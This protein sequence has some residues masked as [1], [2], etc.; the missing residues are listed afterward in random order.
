[1]IVSVIHLENPPRITKGS[2]VL[3]E[4]FVR[5]LLATKSSSDISYG[6]LS[7]IIVGFS[8]EISSECLYYSV[9]FLPNL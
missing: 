1:M 3:S 9:I 4:I 7:E 6:L 2:K 5:V 8:L